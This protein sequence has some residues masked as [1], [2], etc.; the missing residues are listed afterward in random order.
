MKIIVLGSG[1]STGVPEVGCS[2]VVCKSSD[3]RDKRLR[4]SILIISDTNKKILIDCSPDF[5]EQALRHNIKE[6]D[7]VLITHEHY[8]HCYGL[9]DLRTI[10]YKEALPIYGRHSVLDSI[11]KRMHYAFSPTPY[12]GTARLELKEIEDFDQSFMLFDCKITPIRIMHGKLEILGFRINDFVYIT[13]MKTIEEREISKIEGASL[14]IINALRYQKVHPSHHSTQDLIAF[15]KAHNLEEIPC[16]LTH[17]SHHAPIYREFCSLLEKEKNI[18]PAYDS[19]TIE[20]KECKH[21]ELEAYYQ[22]EAFEV[23]SLGIIDYEEAWK[24]QKDSFE[25]I[26]EAKRKGEKTSSIVYVCQHYPVLTMG[27]HAKEANL[28]VSEFLLKEKNIKLYKIERGGDITFHNPDQ[29]VIYPI[30][31]L[32]YYKIGIKEYIHILEASIIELLER[33]NIKAGRKSSAPGVWL[34]VGNQEK[35]RKIAAIGVRSSRFVTMHGLALNISNDLS[36]FDLIN[37]CG[38][39]GGRV[40]SMEKELGY[41]IDIY[42]VAPLLTDIM[43]KNFAKYL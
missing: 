25:G 29:L 12:P 7:A 42:A 41:F 20:L 15:R 3:K 31:D 23:K 1:T 26:I 19:L 27:L 16:Y 35:E 34:D 28:L 6:I 24:I 39:V 11:K 37:P 22:E 5:R 21:E 30:L 36:G 14:M 43:A 10:A 13:D 17:I 18:L 38:F 40:S 32:E 2:C 8:D 9:D 4:S 33:Y